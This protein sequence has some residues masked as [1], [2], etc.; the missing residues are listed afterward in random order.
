MTHPFSYDEPMTQP[1]VGDRVFYPNK[2]AGTV[3]DTGGGVAWVRFDG[4]K[5]DMV[6][7]RDDAALVRFFLSLRGEN[8]VWCDEHAQPVDSWQPG[9]PF[10]SKDEAEEFI[11]A[12]REWFE[13]DSPT[14]MQHCVFRHPE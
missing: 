7:K 3:T 1:I 13:S 6:F 12:S 5:M 9:P 14:R 8:T 2:G 10:A 4:A 11:V